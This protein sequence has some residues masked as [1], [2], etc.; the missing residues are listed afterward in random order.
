ML[1]PQPD[2]TAELPTLESEYSLANEQI[3]SYQSDGHMLLR[4]VALPEEIMVYRRVIEE[5]A[6][7]HNTE[8][9]AMAERDTYD[10]AFL[11]IMNLWTK[12][13]ATKRITVAHR[14]TE[15]AAD[16]FARVIA[17]Q[18]ANH[19]DDIKLWL[20]VSAP[21]DFTTSALNPLI[22]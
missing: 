22:L 10:K 2:T 13:E 5:R 12:N 20:P 9:R 19:E 15:I 16:L 14:F 1:T 11:Q 7:R 6:A 17:P 4:G 21:G 3:S 8:T 18:L